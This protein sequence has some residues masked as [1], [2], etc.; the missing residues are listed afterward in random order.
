VT[1]SIRPEALR[2]VAP[3]PGRD[4]NT[5]GARRRHTVYLGATARHHVELDGGTPL[6][7]L[8]IH[9][10]GEPGVEDDRM[11]LSVSPDDIVMLE[12]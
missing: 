8:T 4:S 10:K 11:H 5:F 2:V 12:N 9:P 3:R 6:E 7:V 1:C